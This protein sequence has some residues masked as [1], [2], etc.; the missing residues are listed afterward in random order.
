MWFKITPVPGF[1]AYGLGVK[2][3]S[4]S[5]FMNFA[6]RIVEQSV[7]DVLIEGEIVE[8][9][10]AA[11]GHVYFTLGD[12]MAQVRCVL[13]KPDAR[14]RSRGTEEA[15][16]LLFPELAALDGSKLEI[17]RVV[18]VAGNADI[19]PMR[20][21][22]Q[23]TARAV[24]D[25]GAADARAL[26]ERVRAKLEPS[27]IFALEKKRQLPRF[28]QVIGVVTSI[29][30]AAIH[31]FL[32][33][34]SNRF[35][36]R[37]LVSPATVQGANAPASIVRALGILH[38]RDVVRPDVIVITRGGG[39]S[40]DLAAFNDERLAR[41]IARCHCPV[42]SAVGHETDVT[43]ADLVADW[44]AATPS[45]AAEI[46]LPDLQ[47]VRTELRNHERHA[48]RSL[49][50]IVT[51]QRLRLSQ[52][53]R[54]AQSRGPGRQIADVRRTLTAR[55]GAL[56]RTL[57]TML[58][59]RRAS[60]TSLQE[61]CDELNP[62]AAVARQRK[63]LDG[64]ERR[65]RSVRLIEERRSRVRHS[66]QGLELSMREHLSASR[67]RLAE[68]AAA[69]SALSPLAVLERGYSIALAPNGRA[70]ANAADVQVGD[71]IRV[72]AHSVRF[73]ASVIKVDPGKT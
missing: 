65:V 29:N 3:Q 47:L 14:I 9:S 50:V 8:C 71:V 53:L 63:L 27:G 17:G 1:D 7:G 41:A 28:P 6:R 39:G 25:A 62:R 11:S 58:R 73:D 30:G 60:L 48:I 61:R 19:Y 56:V 35:P 57:R 42:V 10:K 37:I 51:S 16:K 33:V 40:E 43:I 70:I 18:R 12:R 32:R 22:F 15:D 38:H 68:L 67:T 31:D 54:R 13:F 45:N 66:A 64:L 34:A 20:G 72:R 52:L 46:V 26:F 59:T 5:E 44:R 2:A 55:H 69:L 21:S 4:P 36:T 24:Y 49:D 23:I